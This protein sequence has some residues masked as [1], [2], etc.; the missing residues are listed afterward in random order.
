MQPKNAIRLMLFGLGFLSIGT[1]IYLMREFLVVGNGNEL[2]F[3]VVL[4]LWMLLTGAGAWLGRFSNFLEGKSGL[5]LS[6]IIVAGLLPILMILQLFLAKALLVPHG[7]M[8]SM[9]MLV[10]M[11]TLVQMPFCMLNGFL[12]S[13]LSSRSVGNNLASAYSWESMGS[14]ASGAL[15]N[16]VFLWMFDLW[17]SLL[18]LTA[19]YLILALIFAFN[20]VRRGHFYLTLFF[21]A[22]IL[23]VFLFVDFLKFSES[24]L[25][26]DQQVISNMGTPYGQVVVTKNQ[27][28]YNFY[29]NGL[30]LFSGG[31]EIN[32]EENIHPAM[33]QRNHPRNV[34]LISGGY[35]GTLDE[36]LKYN[37]N[38]IDYVEMNPALILIASKFTSQ[39]DHPAVR[40]HET[41]ARKFV[42][43]T[44]QSYDIAMVNLPAPSTLQLNRYYTLEFLTEIKKKLSPG[45]VIAYSLP[46]GS[47]YVSKDA[48]RLNS[49][50]FQTLKHRFNHVLIIPLQRNYFLASDSALDIDIPALV[51][52]RRIETVYVNQYYLDARQLRERAAYIA[53]NISPTTLTGST[54]LSGCINRDFYPVAT[55]YQNL[56]W[57]G[58]FTVNPL[59]ILV[60]FLIILV[61]LL[62]GLNSVSAGL[63]TGGFTLASTEIILIFS[64]QVIWGYLFQAIGVIIMIFMIGLAVGAASGMRFLRIRNSLF[65]FVLQTALAFYSL[66]LPFLILW[67]SKGKLDDIWVQMILGVCAFQAAFMV[68][69]EY[70]LATIIAGSSPRNVV[71]S[72]YSADLF[73]SAMGAFAT[74]AILFPVFGIIYTGLFLAVLNIFSA[75]IFFIRQRK[76][77]SLLQ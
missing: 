51:Q 72:L 76:L 47:D 59:W 63:F 13:F 4:A 74:A 69:I 25:Y 14:M 65:Y 61:F 56:W 24:I 41:D 53:E 77:V 22:L 36:I 68:G 73:G 15:V 18:F 42:R 17:Q 45:G 27:D 26:R 60:G 7:S 49:I 5:I 44:Q 58:Y 62:A 66:G 6:L 57:L 8:A 46:T 33:V 35:S 37:P 38:L 31:N 50:L 10:T 3:G 11:A 39:L 52:L 9:G 64:L 28:Q 75:M 34:L 70:R 2:I 32:N 48:G 20:M 19:G 71:A 67:L 43:Q 54:T 16:L 21:S 29:E 40:I 12:F 30:L 23:A 1:Q 55:F